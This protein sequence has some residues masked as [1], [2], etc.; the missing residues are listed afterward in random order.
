MEFVS[1]LKSEGFTIESWHSLALHLY[2]VEELEKCE[3]LLQECIEEYELLDEKLTQNQNQNQHSDIYINRLENSI[4]TIGMLTMLELNLALG[5]FETNY[6]KSESIIRRTEE[7]L[8]QFMKLFSCNYS[9]SN[10][11][12]AIHKYWGFLYLYKSV[13][14][15]EVD[16]SQRNTFLDQAEK[17]F[18]ITL[19]SNTKDT[20]A[21]SGLANVLYQKMAFSRALRLFSTLLLILGTEKCPNTVRLAMACCNLRLGNLKKSQECCKRAIYICIFGAKTDDDTINATGDDKEK[22][23]TLFIKKDGKEEAQLNR[24]LLE[25]ETFIDSL[26]QFE[27]Q[28]LSDL[29]L[30]YSKSTNYKGLSLKNTFEIIAKIFPSHPALVLYASNAE[31][32][33]GY[34]P[35][36][37]FEKELHNISKRCSN[38]YCSLEA[39]F[40][41]AKRLHLRKDIA[42][43][44]SHYI[45]VVDVL[46]NFYNT[47]K[48]LLNLYL[49]CLL[50]AIKT[51]CGL[52][53]W[54]VSTQYIHKAFESLGIKGSVDSLKDYNLPIEYL[55]EFLIP[56]ISLVIM[57]IEDPAMIPTTISIFSQLTIEERL[58][59]CLHYLFFILNKMD[60][61][62]SKQCYIIVFLLQKITTC[63]LFRGRRTI[64]RSDYN[65]EVITTLISKYTNY[66]AT[67]KP[68]PLIVIL[69]S[70]LKYLIV[71]CNSLPSPSDS[72]RN[73]S[74]DNPMLNS[75]PYLRY[76]DLVRENFGIYLNNLGVCIME[77]A[78]SLSPEHCCIGSNEHTMLN[79]SLEIFNQ[80]KE[81]FKNSILNSNKTVEI[82]IRFNSAICHELKG[83][84]ANAND[85]Y[86]RLTSEFPWFT[87][88]WLRRA[89]L[90]LER[91]DYQLAAQY[92]ELSLNSKS[93]DIG[94]LNSGSNSE[95]NSDT[96]SVYSWAPGIGNNHESANLLLSHIY[97]CQKKPDKSFSA[98][99]KVIKSKNTYYSNIGK[100]LLG[101]ALYNKAKYQSQSNY[102]GEM[103]MYNPTSIQSRLVLS[104]VLRHESFNYIAS[105]LILIQAAECGLF[106]SSKDMWKY[107]TDISSALEG[108]A[109]CM[110]YVALI[111]LGVL[112]AVL[113]AV[114]T[115]RN[116]P[117]AQH[118]LTLRSIVDDNNVGGIDG[119]NEVLGS[120]PHFAEQ[121]RIMK[122]TV[123]L[124]QQALQFDPTEKTIHMSLI[125]CCFDMNMWEDAR[126]L[127]EKATLRWPS[128]L[129]FKIGLTYCLERLVYSEMGDMERAKHPGRVKYWMMLCEAVGNFYH[130][131]SI[132]KE[133]FQVVDM[134][135]I[136]QIK[137]NKLNVTSLQ[138]FVP[139][140]VMHNQDNKIVLNT[141]NKDDLRYKLSAIPLE[142]TDLLPNIEY[143]TKQELIMSR[144]LYSRFEELLPIVEQVYEKEQRDVEELRIRSEDFRKK[145]EEER[146]RKEE[147]E[148]LASERIKLLSIELG[149]EAESIA[150]SLP[151]IQAEKR[152][153][154]SKRDRSDDLERHEEDDEDD[155]DELASGNQ[156]DPYTGSDSQSETR[157]NLDSSSDAEEK[158]R[159]HASKSSKNKEKK[160]R[161]DKKKKKKQEDR[162]RS[163]NISSENSLSNSNEES[164]VEQIGSKMR[165]SGSESDILASKLKK[166]KKKKS[167]Y[168][169]KKEEKRLL[170]LK[171]LEEQTAALLEEEEKEKKEAQ[172]QENTNHDGLSENEKE[173]DHEESQG[174]LRLKKRRF[175]DTE[176]I[177]LQL[178]G[179]D[180]SGNT[181]LEQNKTNVQLEIQNDQ[182]LSLQNDDGSVNVDFDSRS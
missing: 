93:P 122:T 172:P 141:E 132:I 52:Q 70:C 81:W 100:V 127:L 103:S 123:K 109:S 45:I 71:N 74:C 117:P 162:I 30:C 116:P 89:C 148:K 65:Y 67:L 94:T 23:E 88:A 174:R 135:F 24:D 17:E 37:N 72:K 168:G 121:K 177:D 151:D 125:K 80:S 92:C 49:S 27:R 12:K 83:F 26:T 75:T 2:N 161:K 128:D 91:N 160:S 107:M 180:E 50:G 6:R 139:G 13:I 28:T 9:S 126:K 158:K 104:E 140:I 4:Q 35:N 112:H 110:H 131:L 134:K 175:Q 108:A 36:S 153:K 40:H 136:N 66:S 166:N 106:E 152:S 101:F 33:L 95:P 130:W 120:H 58:L 171:R 155:D 96:N 64:R 167:N 138:K 76:K 15:N 21:I 114:S 181:S 149:K 111:N 34:T 48:T 31:F 59:N 137:N 142:G 3:T 18:T 157:S 44:H 118:N 32:Y 53:K 182:D 179:E 78:T 147:E 51:S 84:Y 156:S 119:R 46:K 86:K 85:E 20:Q 38:F 11:F 79:E 7:R 82:V 129:T 176:D 105:N 146:R 16:L 97:F 69:F 169:K 14:T 154:S 170:K 102:S 25:N 77:C 8:K 143:L 47:D 55:Y 56:T 5:C 99:S 113:L 133:T 63:L 73:S 60:D 163:L 144:K 145:Q 87:S 54:D 98:L 115:Q 124:F 68:I 61:I 178:G 22:M 43:A 150:A 41:I 39:H 173:F 29:L 10:N 90:A 42:N 62:N 164:D 57:S 1:K 165:D 19:E 159:Q